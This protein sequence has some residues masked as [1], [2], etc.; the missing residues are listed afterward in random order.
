M[1]AEI[2]KILEDPQVKSTLLAQGYVPVGS[3]PA[4]LAEVMKDGLAAYARIV[5]HAKIPPE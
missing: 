2:R 4:E 1:S 5:N 3:T